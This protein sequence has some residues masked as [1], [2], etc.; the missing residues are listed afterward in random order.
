MSVLSCQER[1]IC[2]AAPTSRNVSGRG[3]LKNEWALAHTNTRETDARFSL[4]SSLT[5]WRQSAAHMGSRGQLWIS[6]RIST[7]INSWR[8]NQPTCANLRRK[9]S[10]VRRAGLFCICKQRNEWVA[11]SWNRTPFF[12]IPLVPRH[13]NISRFTM[14]LWSEVSLH[15][16]LF[17]CVSCDDF[18]LRI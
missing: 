16:L 12:L 9:L 14:L 11:L 13:G 1:Q 6:L 17:T 8:L 4:T 3:L 10:F 18:W 5:T 2:D 15:K 7:P